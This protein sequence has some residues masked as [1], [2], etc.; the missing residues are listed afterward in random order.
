MICCE[1]FKSDKKFRPAECYRMIWA[2]LAL[3]QASDTY[4]VNAQI[5][6]LRHKRSCE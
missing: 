4:E 6:E 1:A 2:Q 5:L 3:K